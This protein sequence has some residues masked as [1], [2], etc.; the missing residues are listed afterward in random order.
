MSNMSFVYEDTGRHQEALDM[1]ERVLQFH[2]QNLPANHPDIARAM[3]NLASCLNRN[4]ELQRSF[5]MSIEALRMLVASLPPTHPHL[6]AL[7]RQLV[8]TCEQLADWLEKLGRH[9][10]ICVLLQKALNWVSKVTD[11]S[12]HNVN[13]GTLMCKLYCAYLALGQYQDAASWQEQGLSVYRRELPRDHLTTCGAMCNLAYVYSRLGRHQEALELRQKTLEVYRRV[14]PQDHADLGQGM[15]NLARSLQDLGR[16]TTALPLFEESLQFNKRVLPKN[17]PT[18][19]SSMNNVALTLEA[20]GRHKEALDLFEQALELRQRVLPQSDPLIGQSLMNLSSLLRKLSRAKE[21][22]AMSKKA[23]VFFRRYLPPHH[24]ETGWVQYYLCLGVYAVYSLF[25]VDVVRI[26][27]IIALGRCCIRSSRAQSS[28]S[29]TISRFLVDA[30]GGSQHLPAF[31]AVQPPIHQKRH[32]RYCI[33]VP[34]TRHA[35]RTSW[36]LPCGLSRGNQ[37]AAVFAG[38]FAP[39]A[40]NRAICAETSQSIRIES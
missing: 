2:R 35:S 29:Q 27:P 34:G 22:V 31:A 19:A 28:A 23:V 39:D 9:Q 38:L 36:R 24:P 40:S 5:D 15:N 16:F 11:V 26:R 14:L 4:G 18:I 13:V 30:E 21:A 25:W 7:Q 3:H 8:E 12:D 37:F 17:H 33:G 32:R 20:L 6:V 10:D 1:R